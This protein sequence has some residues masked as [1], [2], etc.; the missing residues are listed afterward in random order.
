MMCMLVHMTEN[1]P[2]V[3][4]AA[5]ADLRQRL[6][7]HRPPVLVDGPASVGVDR[8]A[9]ADLLA[10]WRSG[11]DWHAVERRVAAMP[12]ERVGALAFVHQRAERADAPVVVLLHGWPDS[13]LRYERVLPLLEDVHVVVPALPGF[14]FAAPWSPGPID[15][16]SIATA[17]AAVMDQLGYDT[18]TVS[19]GDVGADV[20][21]HLAVH[22]PAA[23]ASLHL[24]NISPLHAVFAD[25]TGMSDLE[26]D[27]LDLV[28]RWSRSE[29]AYVA[30]QSSAPGTLAVGLSDSPAGLAAWLL[31]K[32]TSWS[33]EPPS[34]QHALEWISAYW[35]T[36]TIGSSFATYAA[37][38]P[39]V[40]YVAT[41]TVLSVF[42]HDTKPAPREFAERF[43]NVREYLT[44]SHGGHFAAWEQPE[45]YARDLR[46]ALGIAQTDRSA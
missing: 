15:T 36:N 39:P 29:G 41:P 40:A 20:A 26:L 6:D 5:I 23:V 22:H 4:D 45:V 43:V 11:F 2:R 30:A 38:V 28:A 13:V 21:E 19:A 46:M 18:Y 31:E 16:A 24:T 9:L 12:W 27:Y 14:P 17:V 1:L 32:L 10:A 7:R 35:F 42:G 33:D 8:T 37:F 44:H 34:A 25:R 3:D